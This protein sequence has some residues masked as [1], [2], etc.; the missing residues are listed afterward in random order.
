MSWGRFIALAVSAAEELAGPWQG[1]APEPLVD[2]YLQ[3]AARQPI[4]L[5]VAARF[6]S[7]L[8][9]PVD[10]EGQQWWHSD[11]PREGAFDWVQFRDFEHVYG[12]GELT[13]AGL[14]TVSDPPPDAHDALVGVWEIFPGPVSRW[15]LPPPLGRNV[16]VWEIR[17]PADWVRLVEAYPRPVDRPHGGWELPGPNQRQGDV[18]ELL[19]VP[20]QH[21]VR[22]TVERHL[23]P[24][25]AAVAADYDGVH[26]SWAGFLTTE[27]YVSDAAAGGTT[28]LR[29]WH[30]E[31]T[32]WL[33]DV[34]AEPEPLGPP[35]LSGSMSG[36]LGV[37]VRVDEARREQDRDVITGLLGR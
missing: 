16:R 21:A 2:A 22:V 15:R 10:P 14:R 3:V 1:D 33:A 9:A 13:W 4:A 25:W 6:G 19:A 11:H 24:D 26:L 18:A 27:G 34:F 28:M 32:L 23:V 29:Y 37:D 7:R 12:C 30:S 20:G 17:R 35:V 8:H 5:A 36:T 31:R